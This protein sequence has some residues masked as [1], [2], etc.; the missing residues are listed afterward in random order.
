M[1]ALGQ[2]CMTSG[3]ESKIREYM[4]DSGIYDEADRLFSKGD[5]CE[6]GRMLTRG[7]YDACLTLGGDY[8]FNYNKLRIAVGRL[9][10][11]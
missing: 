7:L 9:V 3:M 10:N 2:L 8:Y 6:A 5:C 4:N 11:L 1:G